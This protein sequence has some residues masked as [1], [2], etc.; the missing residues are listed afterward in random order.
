M[1]ATAVGLAGRAPFLRIAITRGEHGSSSR[2]STSRGAVKAS[3]W[4]MVF[5]STTPICLRS[6]KVG[7]GMTTANSFGS[8]S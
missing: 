6:M 2:Y 5:I 7:T 1:A 8:P 4:S 3:R